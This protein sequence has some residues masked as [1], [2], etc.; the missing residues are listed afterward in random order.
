MI[1][2]I[3]LGNSSADEALLPRA[4]AVVDEPE[5]AIRDGEIRTARL[6]R[7]TR[8]RTAPASMSGQSPAHTTD[9]HSAEAEK[10]LPVAAPLSPEGTVLITGG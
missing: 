9:D 4:I 5:I 6:V 1:R 2:L 7:I 10:Q 8:A 3:D